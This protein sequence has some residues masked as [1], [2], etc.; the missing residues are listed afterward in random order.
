M[1]IDILTNNCSGA[2]I[3]GWGETV[4][5]KRKNTTC[6]T[7]RETYKNKVSTVT[8]TPKNV[9]TQ[10]LQTNINHIYLHWA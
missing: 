9:N 4:T 6:V 2:R 3:I 1:N 5:D 10:Y 7:R 8:T